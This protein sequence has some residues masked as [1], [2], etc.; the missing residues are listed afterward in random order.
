MVK[1]FVF[2]TDL[3]ICS[4]SRVR[5]GDVLEDIAAKLKFV[6]DYCNANEAILLC[7]GDLF[8]KPSV[9][10]YVKSRL[11]PILKELTHDFYSVAGNHSRLYD[12]PE[13][14]YKTSYDVWRSHGILKDLDSVEGVDLGNVFLTGQLPVKTRGKFQIVVYHGF[15]NQEDGRNTLHFDDIQTE[16][17]TYV[18]LGHDHVEYEP[19]QYKENIKIFRPGSLL[20]GIRQDA[21][22]RN[23]QMLHIRVNGKLQ[24]KMVPIKCRDFS[25][26][27]KTKEA[28]VTQSQKHS[29][30][31]DIINQIRNAAQGDLSFEQAISQV[32]DPEVVEFSK[33]LLT[34][35]NQENSNKRQNL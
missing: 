29:T 17:N 16:D 5:N 15:L 26:I 11:A 6:V 8:D 20:R 22:Y 32:A 2:I 23:P 34:Q 4:S 21:Q 7:G 19:V 14:N 33:R 31:E 30:Y 28:K 35:A 1:D 18:L 24:Y 27:F 13:F 9:P 10:D 3:H 25:E 12:N